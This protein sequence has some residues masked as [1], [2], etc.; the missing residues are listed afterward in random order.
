MNIHSAIFAQIEAADDYALKMATIASLRAHLEGL[1]KDVERN[2]KVLDLPLWYIRRATGMMQHGARILL[3][4][5]VDPEVFSCVGEWCTRLFPEERHPIFPG[6]H[7]TPVIIGN[8]STSPKKYF[9]AVPALGN[10]WN[11]HS[12]DHEGI[13]RYLETR[14]GPYTWEK[15]PLDIDG[16]EIFGD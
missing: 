15:L 6:F 12:Y 7:K 16:K 4:E 8:K 11:P 3:R 9:R 5:D 1:A 13:R 14:L 10:L 2:H